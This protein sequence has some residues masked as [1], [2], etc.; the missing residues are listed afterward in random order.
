[1]TIRKNSRQSTLRWA[2]WL[3][4]DTAVVKVSAVWTPADAAA[5]GTPMLISKVLEICPNAMPSAPSTIC[6]A[7]PISD[8]RQ[9]DRWV[10]QERGEWRLHPCWARAICRSGASRKCRGQGRLALAIRPLRT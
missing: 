6:A 3:M 10:G 9:Q 5:G 1:M 8:E 4:P 2:T 7:K